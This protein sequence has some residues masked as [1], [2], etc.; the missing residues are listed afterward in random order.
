MET[1]LDYSKAFLVN[2]HSIDYIRIHCNNPCVLQIGF[3]SGK[4]EDFTMQNE[5]V[6]CK[7][8]EALHGTLR[9]YLVENF[10]SA[11]LA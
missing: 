1:N 3:K 4:C 7:T 2:V 8:F 11:G 10:I 9:R 5:E 6:T